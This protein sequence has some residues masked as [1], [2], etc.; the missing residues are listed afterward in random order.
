MQPKSI[1]PYSALQEKTTETLDFI[2]TNLPVSPTIEQFNDVLLTAMFGS[3]PDGPLSG[4][5]LPLFL[6]AVLPLTYNGYLND[7]QEVECVRAGTGGSLINRIFDGVEKLPFETVGDF[8][9]TMDDAIAGSGLPYQQQMPLFF[10]VESGKAQHAYWTAQLATPGPWALYMNA[11]PTINYMRAGS[12][13]A[14]SIEGALLAYGLIK[15]QQAQFPD[16]LSSMI[17]AIGLPAGKVVFGWVRMVSTG[18]K[19]AGVK[20]K[21]ISELVN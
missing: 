18:F 12:W 5:V 17:G 2:I 3:D 14:A 11:D 19:S 4:D 15:P 21:L 8:L 7:M 13:V 16:I 20:E 1:N 6:N 10:A 9:S